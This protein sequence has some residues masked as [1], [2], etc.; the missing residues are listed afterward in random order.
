[1]EIKIR[2]MVKK[3]NGVTAI[4]DISLEVIEGEM[5]ALLGSSGCGKTTL[6]RTIAGLIHQDCGE[7]YFNNMEVS[8]WPAQK[9][10]AA[11]VFQNYALFPHMN[12][13]ENIAYGL[14]IRKTEKKEIEKKVAEV[15]E[16]VKLIGF[17]KRKIQ[18]LSGGQ[19]QRVA[20]ARSLVIE[21]DILLFDEPLSNLDEKL[22]VSMRQEIRRIQKDTNITSVYVT[23]DQREALSIADRIVVMDSGKICQIGTPEEI[24]YR[25]ANLFTADFMGHL[26]VFSC[27][28]IEENGERYYELFGK[29]IPI[30]NRGKSIKILL[31]PEEI[32]I[33]KNGVDALILDIEPFG[34]V[35]RYKLK[36]K[37][38][39]IYAD[40]IN[41]RRVGS[42]K[43]NDY[44]KIDFDVSA[45][46]VIE[47]EL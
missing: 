37:N 20:L 22:R 47:G 44:I 4:N 7:I 32:D 18:E 42:F 3:F 26:N 8:D 9:R 1:M 23:H 19:K 31:R 11:M 34:S 27:G 24:Y 41:R 39:I 30:E 16:K 13:S 28:I 35:S 5:L 12:V 46:H 6:L 43:V 2:N 15:L 33:S 40:F 36:C 14:K 25:P 10:N 21:P 38:D 17:G 29:K 45:I